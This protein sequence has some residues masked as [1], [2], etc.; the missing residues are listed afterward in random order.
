M[1]K[2]KI[3]LKKEAAKVLLKQ[4]KEDEKKKTEQEAKDNEYVY[5]NTVSG[6]CVDKV[7]Y[8]NGRDILGAMYK[9]VALLQK[10]LLTEADDKKAE[11]LKG[12]IQVNAHWINF[13]EHFADNK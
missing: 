1:G 9:E 12:Q 8:F 11:H 13:V 10:E 4:E 7:W 2:K 5:G 3:N 6:R